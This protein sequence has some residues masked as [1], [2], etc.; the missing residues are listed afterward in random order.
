MSDYIA[1]PLSRVE[2][3]RVALIFKKYFGYENKLYFPVEEVIEKMQDEFSEYGFNFEIVEDKYFANSVQGDTDVMNHYIRIKESVYDNACKGDGTARFSIA[4][5]MGHYVLMCLAEVGFQRNLIKRPVEA[6]EDPEWQANCFAG[7]L[8]MP[9]TFIQ[10]MSVIEIMGKCN[11][12][13]TAAN[14]QKN[15]IQLEKNSDS[16]TVTI[17]DRKYDG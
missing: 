12:S 7:E 5:E 4:H 15:H 17:L 3:R 8:L 6:Y 2:I 13:Y 14:Y 10:D 9:Y 11:V 1:K 16:T